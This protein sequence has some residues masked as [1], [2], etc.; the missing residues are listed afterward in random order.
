MFNW[1]LL[2]GRRTTCCR[3]SGKAISS[4]NKIGCVFDCFSEI[5][6]VSQNFGF[7]QISNIT[8]YFFRTFTFC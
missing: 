4:I 7:S 3:L 8:S 2:N 5:I 6:L 1:R